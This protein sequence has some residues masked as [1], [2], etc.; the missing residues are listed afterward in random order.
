MDIPST[1]DTSNEI[2]TERLF[3]RQFINLETKIEP[4]KFMD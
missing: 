4:F 1:Q 2:L 3:K